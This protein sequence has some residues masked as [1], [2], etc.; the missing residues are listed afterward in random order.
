[1]TKGPRWLQRFLHC[2]GEL[3]RPPEK[4]HKANRERRDQRLKGD[5]GTGSLGAGGGGQAFLQCELGLRKGRAT[6]EVAPTVPSPH[7]GHAPEEEQKDVQGG[8][9]AQMRLMGAR[10]DL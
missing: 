1:M 4:G 2:L 6:L 10:Q 9:E 7:P 5:D 3:Q 8:Q